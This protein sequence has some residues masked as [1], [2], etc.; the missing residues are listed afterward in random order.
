MNELNAKLVHMIKDYDPKRQDMLC[1]IDI[2]RLSQ[3]EALRN[4]TGDKKEVVEAF[5]DYATAV[6]QNHPN[7]HLDENIKKM[8]GG[9]LEEMKKI[10]PVAYEKYEAMQEVKQPETLR[11]QNNVRVAAI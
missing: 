2:I 5:L 4:P 10:A 3:M 7:A 1:K 11:F 8:F 9:A 6:V